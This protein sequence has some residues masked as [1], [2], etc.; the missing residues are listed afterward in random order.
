MISCSHEKVNSLGSF[1][2]AAELNRLS[3]FQ[4]SDPL[5]SS[6]F[7]A[8]SIAGFLLAG[9]IKLERVEILEENLPLLLRYLSF[10]LR[11]VI[12]GLYDLKRHVDD[13]TLLTK[14]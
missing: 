4:G 13:R 3:S 12:H 6:G 9:W 11:I 5:G 1:L 8:I 2:V 10:V 14:E 7:F